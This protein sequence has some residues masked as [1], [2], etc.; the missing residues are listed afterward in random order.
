MLHAAMAVLF[1]GLAAAQA[2]P[3]AVKLEK[4]VAYSG[5]TSMDIALPPGPGPHPAVVAIHG[6]GF[7]A[8][9]RSSY[10]EMISR[11]AG[12]GYVA[13]TVDY[14]L[15]PAAQFPSALQDVKAAVRFLRANAQKYNID[16]D[17]IA[18]I[19]DSAGATLA[20]LLGLTPEVPEF[21]SGG[22]NRDRSSRI[23]CVVS[24]AGLAELGRLEVKGPESATLPQFL[25]GDFASVPREYQLASPV[26]WITPAA[27]PVLAIHGARDSVVPPDQ[28]NLLV[29]ALHRVGAEGEL[30]SVD[31]G[32]TL[33]GAAKA[34]AERRIFDFLD[35]HLG[36]AS[37]ET[38]V[39]VADHGGKHQVA[40]I[41][42]P[43]GR[44]LWAVPNAGGHD[45]QP[46]PDGHVLFTL[47][48]EHKVVELDKNR[49]PV[50][51]YG[52]A[53]GLQHP[54]SAQ[55]LANGNTL[56]GDAQTGKVIEVDSGGKVVWTYESADL[57]NMR[58]RNSRRLPGGSTL[59]SVEAAG[60]IIEVNS[61]GEIIWTYT[62]E[63]GPKRRPY[64]GVRLPNGNTLITL[65]APGE[66]VEVDRGGKIVR[67]IA[68][69]KND[70]RMIWASGFDLLPNGNILLNDY[71]GHRILEI[72]ADGK[73]A[74]EV[75]LPG[76]N[77]AS[78]AV[79][80]K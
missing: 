63:G 69:E 53:E 23:A 66:L 52:P 78:I 35:H 72:R 50:W 27:P 18:A 19:G 54:I 56:I 57:A 33:D 74:H 14:R 15:A 68:G 16:P 77:I 79:V 31:A 26:L 25:G 51:T 36:V 6:G 37:P 32:H 60:K 20:L 21:D 47:G 44:E 5:R 28:S 71:L 12:H 11:L 41:E 43:S 24:I 22:P 17:R 59:I 65:T 67:S 2:A 3:D 39:L 49:K 13:A 30:M 9:D 42:W 29:E 8:G 64:K 7:T 55:R 76:R 75:R 1:C 48:P 73:V 46:L 61:A 62:G 58:M 38:I 80:P 70:I 4:Q 10:G 40:A 34:A 45:V